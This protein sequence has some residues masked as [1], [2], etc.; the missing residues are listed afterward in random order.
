MVRL[1]R[2]L[3]RVW[4]V[5]WFVTPWLWRLVL[6]ILM[7]LGTA[8]A[9]FWG[10]V[11]NATASIATDWRDRAVVAGF[12]TEWDSRLFF[13]FWVIAFGMI[14]IGWIVLSYITVF[15]VQWIF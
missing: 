12:P 2:F 4:W 10:N 14:V 9:A 7:W 1:E 13:L 8:F 3:G 5:I 11:P 15:V 6:A